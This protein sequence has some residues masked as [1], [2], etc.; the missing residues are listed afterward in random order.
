MVPGD[1]LEAEIE[2]LVGDIL[3]GSLRASAASAVP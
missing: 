3:A 2:R 1:D